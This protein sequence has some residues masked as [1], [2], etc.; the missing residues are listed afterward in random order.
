ME[1]EILEALKEIDIG[2]TIVVFQL[3]VLVGINF[4]GLFKQ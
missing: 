4:A 3:A 2:I 1:K